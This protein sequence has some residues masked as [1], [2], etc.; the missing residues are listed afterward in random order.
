MNEGVIVLKK[1]N[2][3]L[4]DFFFFSNMALIRSLNFTEDSSITNFILKKKCF[5][6]RG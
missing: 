3:L 4:L 6:S 5:Q 1:A 2:Y